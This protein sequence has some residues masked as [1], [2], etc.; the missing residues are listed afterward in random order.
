MHNS[1]IYVAII[2]ERTINVDAYH[3]IAIA[4]LKTISK[5]TTDPATIH[6]APLFAVG[7]AELEPLAL[8][9]GVE[10]MPVLAVVAP[11]VPPDVMV[12]PDPEAVVD[13]EDCTPT[14][15]FFAV[16]VMV[17]GYKVM[18]VELSWAVVEPSP[19]ASKP[20]RFCVH[21]AW[22]MGEPVRA[23][24]TVAVLIVKVSWFDC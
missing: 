4:I 23:Q 5:P 7:L 20:M 16:A 9:V 14:P 18:S 17:T 12:A 2:A 3:S 24:S 1:S 15:T 13:T 11:V 21:M 8:P 19:L 10:D 22:V 6:D